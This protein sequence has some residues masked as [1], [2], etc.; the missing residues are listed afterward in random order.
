MSK[1][2]QLLDCTPRII[3]VK[4]L[5]ETN[6]ASLSLDWRSFHDHGPKNARHFFTSFRFEYKYLLI[7]LYNQLNFNHHIDSLAKKLNFT[8]FLLN[9]FFFSGFSGK[10]R[11]SLCF[12]YCL[13][14]STT[15]GK[16]DPPILFHEVYYKFCQ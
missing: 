1:Q 6:I 8:T 11:W 12:D 3:F 7:W 10:K 5:K 4:L 2:V 13:V 9:D 14:N 16:P 15:L